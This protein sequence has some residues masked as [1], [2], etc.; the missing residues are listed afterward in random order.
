MGGAVSK[1]RETQKGKISDLVNSFL[2]AT[3]SFYQIGGAEWE[4][5]GAGDPRLLFF[6]LKDLILHL[7]CCCCFNTFIYV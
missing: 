4:W 2:Q 5:G 7:H 1:V 6:S 3:Q